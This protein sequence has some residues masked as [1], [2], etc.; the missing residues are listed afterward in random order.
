METLNKVS[1]LTL[2]EL[3]SFCKRAGW[4]N[5]SK[6]SKA[7]LIERIIQAG[8]LDD[9]LL[10]K[11]NPKHMTKGELYQFLR[12][13]NVTGCSRLNKRE[14]IERIERENL[15]EMLKQPLSCEPIKTPANP[16][17][18][19]LGLNA[20]NKADLYSFLKNYRK[21]CSRDKKAELVQKIIDEGLEKDCLETLMKPASSTTETLTKFVEAQVNPQVNEVEFEEP[22]PPAPSNTLDK[23]ELHS[24]LK[25]FPKGDLIEYMIE[26]GIAEK[27]I[28]RQSSINFKF[29]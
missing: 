20:F 28:D 2:L 24:I 21:G 22:V 4:K 7:E 23:T 29:S 6:Q 25:K 10:K 11:Y 18:D 27:F 3:R 9:V 13:Q 12:N 14:L 1:R 19:D 8:L 15:L 17:I 16:K 26:Q 5:Y